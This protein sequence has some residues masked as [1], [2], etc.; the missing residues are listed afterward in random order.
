MKNSAIQVLALS[1]T[2]LLTTGCAGMLTPTTNLSPEQIIAQAKDKNASITCGAGVGTGGKGTL[3]SLNLDKAV[4]VN[5][6]LIVDPDCKTTI[7]TT[8]APAVKP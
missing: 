4:I 7:T 5:G 2:V 6:T 3:L 8:N 1:A